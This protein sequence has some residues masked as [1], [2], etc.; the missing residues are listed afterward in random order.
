MHVEQCYLVLMHQISRAQVRPVHNSQTF[1][2]AGGDHFKMVNLNKHLAIK[3]KSFKDELLKMKLI[4]VPSNL[5]ILNWI[6]F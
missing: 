4:N 1:T 5:K 6:F 3:T 2:T